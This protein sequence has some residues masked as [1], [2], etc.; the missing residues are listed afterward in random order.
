MFLALIAYLFLIRIVLHTFKMINLHQKA[1]ESI[2]HISNS[3]PV[4]DQR[5]KLFS[6]KEEIKEE[7]IEKFKLNLINK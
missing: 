4:K 5:G 3:A 7:K 1:F 2:F 6:I